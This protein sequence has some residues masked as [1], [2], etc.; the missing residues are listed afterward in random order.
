MKRINVL[1]LMFM[2]CI[3]S[4]LPVNAKTTLEDP[5]HVKLEIEKLLKNHNLDLEEDIVAN[6]LFTINDDK[7][8]VVLIIDSEDEKVKDFIKHRLNYKKIK[9]SMNSDFDNV[10]MPVRIK[11]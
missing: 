6:V 7:E 10:V 1:M 11:A 3:G 2:I 8:L 4:V 9:S 5:S